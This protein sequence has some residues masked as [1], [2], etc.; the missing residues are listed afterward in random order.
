MNEVVQEQVSIDAKFHW[1]KS[2]IIIGLCVGIAIN[3]ALFWYLSKPSNV[4][5]P[6]A[7]MV[8][9][10]RA[11]GPTTLCKGETLKY[12]YHL[13]ASQPSIVDVSTTT[14]PIKPGTIDYGSETKRQPFPNISD[15]TFSESWLI[16]GNIAPGEYVRV[17]ALSSPGRYAVTFGTLSFKVADCEAK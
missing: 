13:D 5:L 3:A 15:L 16:P 4:P 6:A 1:Y 14:L 10:L 2:L 8:V 11:I 7:V 9:D 17:I 12:E